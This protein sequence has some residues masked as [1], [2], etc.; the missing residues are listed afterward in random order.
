MKFS[1]YT[2]DFGGLLIGEILN[3]LLSFE[4]KFAP[5]TLV[6]SIVKRISMTS[7]KMHVPER[8]RN[9]SVTH[10]NGYLVKTF[11]EQSPKIPV[12]LWRAS[13]CAW[14]AFNRTIEV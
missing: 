2:V 8:R 1:I 4:V 13:S 11:R 12:I 5:E 9:A 3:P 14:I 10:D 6:L 7:K